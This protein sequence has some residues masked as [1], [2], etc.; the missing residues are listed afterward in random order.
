VARFRPKSD[1][2]ALDPG[3]FVRVRLDAAASADGAGV[4]AGAGRLF[5]PA[6][7]I[8]SRG[9]LRG[10]YVIH[11]GVARLRWLRTGHDTNGQVEIL[12]GLD[13]GASVAAD[14]KD[15]FDGRPVRTAS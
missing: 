14:P 10:A 13:A 9:A 5:L 3:A 12:A 8:V 1:D 15:L 2:F 11:D 7:S 6:A 4:P